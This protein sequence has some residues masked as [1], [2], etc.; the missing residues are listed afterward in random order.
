MITNLKEQIYNLESLL[1]ELKKEYE[2]ETERIY[3]ETPHKSFKKGDWVCNGERYGKVFWV[4]NAACNL[5]E[6]DGYVGI[7]LYSGSRGFYTG[8]RDD[9]SLM[10]EDDVHYLTTEHDIR[11]T[12]EEIQVV[13]NLLLYSCSNI[14]NEVSKKLQKIGNFSL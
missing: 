1:S 12:G 3:R 2:E 14:G 5:K 7:D 4:E 11:L 6:E 13:S 10:S 9:W 8:K